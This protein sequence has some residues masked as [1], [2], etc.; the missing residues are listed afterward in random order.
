MKRSSYPFQQFIRQA[1]LVIF[2][3]CL[4]VVTGGMLA[5]LPEVAR[6]IGLLVIVA[7]VLAVCLRLLKSDKR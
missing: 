4:A 1:S 3:G 6:L 2:I 7:A 5:Q